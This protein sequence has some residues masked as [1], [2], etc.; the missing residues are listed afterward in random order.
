MVLMIVHMCAEIDA[1]GPN[2]LFAVHNR[3]FLD[4]QTDGRTGRWDYTPFHAVGT[5]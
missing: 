4:G 1:F 5:V 3:T 2:H